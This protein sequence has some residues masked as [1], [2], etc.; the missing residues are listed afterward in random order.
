MSTTL[1]VAVA[2]IATAACPLHMWWQQR[3]GRR[4]ICCPPSRTRAPDDL[5]ALRSRQEDLGRRVAS[6]SARAPVDSQ[7]S[8][9]R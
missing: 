9:G 4:A 2:V 8:R 7:G 3:R 6:L 5:E 1:F